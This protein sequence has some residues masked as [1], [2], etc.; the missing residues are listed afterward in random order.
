MAVIEKAGEN[1]TAAENYFNKVLE[2]NPA[3]TVCLMALADIYT[4]LG[5]FEPALQLLQSCLNSELDKTNQKSTLIS[6]ARLCQ[7]LD[8]QD[9]AID[10]Y[11]QWLAAYPRSHRY[12]FDGCSNGRRSA[13]K[14]R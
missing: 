1:Y 11:Q 7:L 9:A 14:T 5:H 6:M 12:S 4:T 10:I 2:R 13:R 8:N 3:H